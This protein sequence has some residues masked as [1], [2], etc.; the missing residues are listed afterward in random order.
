MTSVVLAIVLFVS[1][2]GMSFL[3]LS[4]CQVLRAFF[5][6]FDLISKPCL[7]CFGFVVYYLLILGLYPFSCVLD[8]R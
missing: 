5:F 3:F 1:R 6:L 2:L 7:A 4:G 8:F